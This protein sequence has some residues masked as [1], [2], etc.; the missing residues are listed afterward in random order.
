MVEKTINQVPLHQLQVGQR[1]VVL[2]VGGK[3]P[4]RQR[5]MD[6]G[7][8]PGAEVKVM[9]VAPLGDPVE[10]QLRG[11]NLSLRKSDAHAITVRV[12]EGKSQ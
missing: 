12:S 4:A 5:M 3:G 6:M 2:Q 9:R 8:V 11:Y 1:G 7:L 10:F